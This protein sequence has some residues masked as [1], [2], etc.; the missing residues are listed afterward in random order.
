VYA[1]R[2]HVGEGLGSTITVTV[3]SFACIEYELTRW[4]ACTM[5]RSCFPSLDLIDSIRFD[6]TRFDSLRL[7]RS[8]ELL[9]IHV[10]CCVGLCC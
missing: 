1:C 4:F 6:S 8:L 7:I 5:H 9:L 10:L 3:D 2:D